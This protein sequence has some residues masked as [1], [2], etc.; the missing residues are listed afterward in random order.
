[1]RVVDVTLFYGKR[2]GGI[3]TYLE[4]KAEY[5]AR[6][7][8][9]EHHLVIPTE[10]RSLRIVSSNGYRVPL[11]PA[12]LG[13]TLRE[14]SPDVVLL[15]DPYWTPRLATRVAHEVGA[16]VVA[17]HHS[18]AALH[19]AGLP[20]PDGIYARA[21]GRWYRRAYRDVDAIMTVVD[22]EVDVAG[23][24]L[25]P[26]RLG[27]DPA[28]HP[29]LEIPRGDHVLYVGRLARE[30]GLREL[31]EAASGAPEPWPLHL[32]GTGPAEDCLRD[33]A[34]QLGLADR[35]SLRPFLASRQ[36]LAEAYAGARCVVLPGAHETF[37]LVALEAAACGV[38]VVTARTT[39]SSRLLGRLGGTFVAGDPVDLTRAITRARGLKRDPELGWELARDHAWDAALSAELRELQ[40]F[41]GAARACA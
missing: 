21:L 36:D 24:R 23:V 10:Q 7:G 27:V 33:R 2:S 26:L 40:S 14:L 17:V 38:P 16:S 28:F 19:A 1:M 29:R 35:L 20:G 39:P 6:S 4:A 8:A 31:L 41:V 3:R 13:P 11:G 37:G 30:K 32:V 5:A 12:G 15:H 25:L 22:P 18:S 34:R 9:F